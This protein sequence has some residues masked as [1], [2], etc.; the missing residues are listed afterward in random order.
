MTIHYRPMRK[1]VAVSDSHFSSGLPHILEF[2]T[3]TLGRS[4]H[5]LFAVAI[6]LGGIYVSA[7]IQDNTDK[8]CA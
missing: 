6:L 5:S 2:S 3:I 7:F 8:I 1:E 4:I